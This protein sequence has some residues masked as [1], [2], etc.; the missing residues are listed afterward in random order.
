MVVEFVL[1]VVCA[2]VAEG[3]MTRC[4]PSLSVPSSVSGV[5]SH[6][7]TGCDLLKSLLLSTGKL[8]LVPESLASGDEG[9]CALSDVSVGCVHSSNAPVSRR[10]IR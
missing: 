7:G 4:H 8:V 2:G 1:V 9:C 5:S 3:R 6:V 10:V